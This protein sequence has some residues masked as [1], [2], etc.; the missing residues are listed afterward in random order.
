VKTLIVN[1]LRL[2]WNDE[3]AARGLV[4]GGLHATAVGGALYADQ[5]ASVIHAPH[6]VGVIKIAAF[7]AAF[8]GGNLIAGQ[9]NP[10]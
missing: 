9:T 5:I 1:F 6:L 7:S 2:V 3:N 10:K 4:R 8:L